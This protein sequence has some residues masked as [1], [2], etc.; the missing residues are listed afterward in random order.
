MEQATWPTNE[1]LNKRR[2]QLMREMA[3]FIKEM[4]RL[5][6]IAPVQISAPLT[7]CGIG[8][9]EAV[10]PK[11]WQNAIDN[12]KQMAVAY[13]KDNFPELFKEQL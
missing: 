11:E 4:T 1:Y 2:E 6:M 5:M 7:P 10:M 13:A 9:V 12:I 3:P 8:K